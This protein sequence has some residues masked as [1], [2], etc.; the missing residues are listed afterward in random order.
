MC[1]EKLELVLQEEAARV[2]DGR[3]VSLDDKRR[4]PYHQAVLYE[5]ARYDSILPLAVAHATTVDT[6]LSGHP[7]PKGE[8]AGCFRLSQSMITEFQCLYL[9]GYQL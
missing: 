6:E 5:V 9:K 7:I 3:A 8:Q 1:N 2:L 4:L